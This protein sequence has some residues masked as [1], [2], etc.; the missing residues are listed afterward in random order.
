MILLKK[1][2]LEKQKPLTQIPFKGLEKK[3]TLQSKT[4]YNKDDIFI[5][6]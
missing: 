2:R 6:N 1:W 5:L 4:I 3:E